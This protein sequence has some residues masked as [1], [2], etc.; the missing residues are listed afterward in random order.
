[1]AL[2]DQYRGKYRDKNVFVMQNVQE[3]VYTGA[4]PEIIKQEMH[5]LFHDIPF[6]EKGS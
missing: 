3:I 2:E 1:M 6:Y 5:K 4:E